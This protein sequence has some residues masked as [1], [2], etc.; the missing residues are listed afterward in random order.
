MTS[1]TLHEYLVIKKICPRWILQYSPRQ[2]KGSC[3]LMNKKFKM[4]NPNAQKQCITSKQI[5]NLGCMCMSTKV[6]IN[7]EMLLH[8]R[9]LS[10]KNHL[11][12]LS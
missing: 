7:C 2:N 9:I 12:N 8:V 3:R 4:W 11:Q 6:N 10:G 5:T 1:K